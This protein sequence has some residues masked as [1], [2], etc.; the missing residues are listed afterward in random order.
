MAAFAL[1]VGLPALGWLGGVNEALSA[2]NRRLAEAPTLSLDGLA[3]FPAAFDR[4]FRDHFGFRSLLIRKS[5]EVVWVYDRDRAGIS[6]GRD[7]WL[8]MGREA[9]LPASHCVRLD[10]AELAPWLA[11]AERRQRWFDAEGI[12]FLW[13]LAPNKHTVHPE[14]FP[15]TARQR[16]A[17]DC[18]TDGL[19]ARLRREHGV[20]LLDLRGPFRTRAARER[21][22]HR[23]DTHWNQ[24]GGLHGARLVLERLRARFPAVRLPARDDF[25]VRWVADEH[26][27][28]LSNQLSIFGL[29]YAEDRAVLA[30]R[31]PPRARPVGETPPVD[32][33]WAGHR[34]ARLELATGDPR[35]PRAVVFHDS[36]GYALIPI[37]AEQ[38][39]EAVF[40]RT[41]GPLDLALVRRLRPDVV[42]AVFVE[43]KLRVAAPEDPQPP[44][45]GSR[46]AA[47]HPN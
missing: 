40:V 23:T 39:Q 30:R 43:E 42:V 37:L 13:V 10:E 6:I 1:L 12:P 36:F 18:P 8:Y 14:F 5:R 27:G 19:A 26:G 47:R 3:G 45:P 28:N 29:R 24:L 2:E 21:L 20:E 16:L 4:H 46:T 15:D 33:S 32:P 11:L 41:G 7:G 22:Y 44:E 34:L 31:S 38:L 17:E 25:D 35:L 9:E